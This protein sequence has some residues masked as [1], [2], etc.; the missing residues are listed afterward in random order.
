MGRERVYGFPPL[1]G[2]EQERDLGEHILQ[3]E[4]NVQSERKRARERERERCLQEDAEIPAGNGVI[5]WLSRGSASSLQAAK[6]SPGIDLAV[7]LSTEVL[8]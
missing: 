7:H 5:I 2:W 3:N 6:Q 1:N 8:D 4:W